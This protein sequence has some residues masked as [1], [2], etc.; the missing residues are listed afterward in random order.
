MT[1][2]APEQA[3]QEDPAAIAGRSGMPGQTRGPPMEDQWYLSREGQQHGPYT[4]QQLAGHARA[5]LVGGQ[6][7]IWSPSTGEW[8]PVAGHPRLAAALSPSPPEEPPGPPAPPPGVPVGSGR[9]RRWVWPAAAAIVAVTVAAIAVTVGSD[10]EPLAGTVTSTATGPGHTGPDTSEAADPPDDQG[11]D[12]VTESQVTVVGEA[13]AADPNTGLPNRPPVRLEHPS[14]ASA[15]VPAAPVK[16][17]EMVDLRRLE[18]PDDSSAW[19]WGGVGWQFV[20]AGGLVI[21]DAVTLTLPATGAPGETVLA[22]GHTGDWIELPS[23]PATL[24]SG[25]PA[26]RVAVA[27][28]PAPW[29]MV[30]ATPVPG[31]EGE[32]ETPQSTVLE[33]LYWTD[34][35]EWERLTIEFLSATGAGEPATR[36]ASPTAVRST[37]PGIHEMKNELVDAYLHL[38]AARMGRGLDQQFVG[39]PLPALGLTPFALYTEGLDRLETAR[40]MWFAN[41]EYWEEQEYGW[42]W[43]QF[44]SDQTL[45][46]ALESALAYYAPWGIDLIRFL[47]HTGTI[48]TFDL[49]VIGPYGQELFADAPLTTCHRHDEINVNIA[50]LAERGVT[51]ECYM[52]LYSRAAMQHTWIDWLKDWKL[53]ALVRYLPAVLI[54]A[55]VVSG[56]AGVALLFA[57]ADQVISWVQ[58]DYAEDS[59][60]AYLNTEV[61]QTTGTVGS[62]VTD[63]AAGLLRVEGASTSLAGFSLGA[64]QSLYSVAVLY[65]V[66]QTNWYMLQ[67]VKSLTDHTRSYCPRGTC[68]G[69]WY[70]LSFDLGPVAGYDQIPPIQVVAVTHDT[71]RRPAHRYP[72]HRTRVQVW[73]L[74]H[75]GYSAD[76]HH[77]FTRGSRC[78]AA[79]LGLDRTLLCPGSGGWEKRPISGG[80]ATL[81]FAPYKKDQWP[82]VTVDTAPAAQ[83]IRV[84]VAKGVLDAIAADFKLG[85]NPAFEDYFLVV[86]ARAPDGSRTTFEITELPEPWP[87][88]SRDAVHFNIVIRGRWEG[89]PAT[90]EG[91][92]KTRYDGSKS[93][94]RGTPSGETLQTMLT[95]E[96]RSSFDQE[97]RAVAV[98]DFTAANTEYIELLPEW[99][100]GE[101]VHL[102]RAALGSGFIGKWQGTAPGIEGGY[103]END[104]EVHLEIEMSP[105][106]THRMAK[107][108][109][110]GWVEGCEE[111]GE[112]CDGIFGS[113]PEPF[114]LA[115]V[116]EDDL[117]RFKVS[118][119]AISLTFTKGNRGWALEGTLK[120]DGTISGTWEASQSGEVVRQGKWKVRRAEE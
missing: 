103:A 45:E 35:A 10:E 93:Q 22:L 88:E 85:P 106:G 101:R 68:S 47:I 58:S 1:P 120:D 34:R 19:Q 92:D 11:E 2:P 42:S 30:V 117:T 27:D 105:E 99:P 102:A 31:T 108:S 67:E 26:R 20:S 53:Q 7:L 23:E 43:Y 77:L 91:L 63:A 14:G 15:D 86:D 59:P 24:P 51:A 49:G 109:L 113:V 98:V 28:V 18:I 89:K 62:F 52:R 95:L 40:R 33:Q 46:Q 110:C 64:V 38:G 65:G 54:T 44:T 61:A 100:G 6:D 87:G 116:S 96:V 111:G 104:E 16:Y 36:S 70:H 29:V 8:Q 13:E 4:W 73:T 57:A 80:L 12:A 118:G 66:S 25:E 56:S 48:A 81:P 55:G 107:A 94:M 3:L 78:E 84:S 82:I 74:Y 76:L 21:T 83:S 60:S 41:K 72:N 17:S 79:T 71:D 5:G 50:R 9:S 39:T 90:L 112:G 115:W 69:P 75:P 119:R 32:V 97:P 37:R 114:C